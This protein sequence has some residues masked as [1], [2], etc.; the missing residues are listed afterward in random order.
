[1]EK[2][3][4]SYLAELARLRHIAHMMGPL[5]SIR[6]IFDR[7]HEVYGNRLALVEKNKN[8]VIEYTTA[9]FYDMVTALGTAMIDIGLEGRHIAII[10]ENSVRWVVAFFATVCGV[11]VAVPIDKELSDE[12]I[13]ALLTKA[14]TDAAFFSKTY[15][16][17]VKAHS[18]K[19]GNFRYGI[20]LNKK[21][22]DGAT[23]NIDELI[24]KGKELIKNGD[25]RFLDKKIEPDALAAIIFTS[26]TTGANKGVMLSHINFAS[27]VD[28]IIDAIKQE[29]T[30]FSVLPMNH[31][32]ELSCNILTSVYMN[33]VIYVNDSIRNFAENMKLFQPEAMAIVPLVV[34]TIYSTI[35]KKA[36]ESG[37]ADALR[38]LIKLSNSLLSHGIDVR[39]VLFATIRKNFGYKF[40]TFSC[41]GAP[42]RTE[43]LKC[44]GDFGFNIYMGYGLTEASP[45]V[46]LNLDAR[47]NPS[48]AGFVFPKAKYKIVDPD[49]DGVGE[50]Y[51]K[52]ENL[53]KGY[54]K[55]EKATKES[56]TEDG[57]FRTGDYGRRGE[58]GELYVVGRKKNLIILDNGKNIYPEE[59][60]TFMMENTELIRE[61]VA[62]EAVKEILGKET[63]IMAV[64]VYADPLD[65]PGKSEAEVK[66]LAEKA[67]YEANKKQPPY[68]KIQDVF[69]V[70]HEFEKTSTLKTIRKKVEEQY[71]ALLGN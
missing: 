1:M 52:G 35:W 16:K 27:N 50:I 3:S 18:S 65:Y 34:D 55:D 71:Y 39:N 8:E 51:I 53:T 41:G 60:E 30:S 29:A 14:D 49:E 45:T 67:I 20:A 57:W 43:Y 68:R 36:E 32:Y 23:L 56:F 2:P 24:A 62:F 63:K 54:Y 46:T 38:K 25:R 17:G 19:D 31:T 9:Q 37:K 15:Y 5:T 7:V 22:D 44:L 13:S 12:E 61:V 33:A 4:K 64:G 28:G 11:G 69:V 66:E 48:S 26:G 59:I 10:S 42:T 58:K 40:P 6:D 47:G 21:Y 70:T